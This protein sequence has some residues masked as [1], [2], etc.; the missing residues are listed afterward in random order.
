MNSTAEINMIDQ[1][2]F[3]SIRARLMHKE[4]GEGWSLKQTVAVEFEYRRFLCL[5]KL[6]PRAQV[7][8]VLEVDVFWHY[9]IL[10]TEKYAADCEQI[11][12]Y[13][14]HHVPSIETNDADDLAAHQ[15]NGARMQELYAATYIKADLRKNEASENTTDTAWCQPTAPKTAWCQPAM[16]QAAWCQ[17]PTAKT[18]WCQPAAP[19]NAWC[20][21]S[22]PKAAWRQAATA[23]TAWCQPSTAKN[24]LRQAAK[25]IKV[26]MQAA[27][28]N[29]QFFLRPELARAA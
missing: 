4:S 10:D 7:A 2:N 17:P 22:L 24:D 29:D 18:A 21:P 8:P 25:A 11:F 20:Q 9:H 16:P 1:L 5:M 27:A 28:P 23:I 3:D 6:F 12:G 19:T 13:F 26:K 14:L 15:R